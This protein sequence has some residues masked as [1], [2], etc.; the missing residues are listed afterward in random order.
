MSRLA[1][2]V[3]LATVAGASAAAR[4]DASFR[5]RQPLPKSPAGPTRSTRPTPKPK[6]PWYE[7]RIHYT[8][9]SLRESWVWNA[10]WD[11]PRYGNVRN[12]DEDWTVRTKRP[13]LIARCCH[14]KDPWRDAAGRLIWQ[15][16]D[17][18]GGSYA[19]GNGCFGNGLDQLDAELSILRLGA[20]FTLT[21]THV[22]NFDD[23]EAATEPR[24]TGAAVW[25]TGKAHQS[26]EVTFIRRSAPP[27]P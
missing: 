22:Q 6:P 23:G 8:G 15:T 19:C 13:V 25:A 26:W 10:G 18:P 16:R 4:A 27:S 14:G 1:L 5:G 3:L 9:T 11:R 21:F 2:I 12:V 20:R 24:P 7:I 17:V